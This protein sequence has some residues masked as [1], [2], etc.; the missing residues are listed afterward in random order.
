MYPT[1]AW[2]QVSPK[3]GV[4]DSQAPIVSVVV[5]LSGA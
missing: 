1:P 4:S 3:A 5:V 2:L